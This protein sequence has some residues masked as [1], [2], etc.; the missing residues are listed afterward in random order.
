MRKRSQLNKT[1][2]ET[3]IVRARALIAA[4]VAIEIDQDLPDESPLLRIQHT[5]GAGTAAHYARPG[6]GI[7]IAIWLR[8]VALK[9]DVMICGTEISVPWKDDSF[10]LQEVFEKVSYYEVANGPEYPKASVLN[11]RLGRRLQ[12][13]QLLEGVLIARIS[14]RLP[15]FNQTGMVM[16]ITVCFW[17]QLETRIP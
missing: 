14:G 17:D 9:P 10:H 16:P 12:V 6:R 3:H 4:G 8:I 15:D 13:R 1:Q 11:H 2:E 7:G 5:G